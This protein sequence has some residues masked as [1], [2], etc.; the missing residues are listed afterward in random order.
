MPVDPELLPSQLAIQ[1]LHNEL[2][3]PSDFRVN[4]VDIPIKRVDPYYVR[5]RVEQTTMSDMLVG[6]H[7]G[8]APA[9]DYDMEDF[10]PVY[11]DVNATLTGVSV[12]SFGTLITKLRRTDIADRD[13]YEGRSDVT[14]F[15]DDQALVVTWPEVLEWWG[16][17]SLRFWYER[18]PMTEDEEILMVG[19]VVKLETWHRDAGIPPE[20]QGRIAVPGPYKTSGH[21]HTARKDKIRPATETEA[22][23]LINIINDLISK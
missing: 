21:R 19:E 20:L 1:S 15:E 7:E 13:K 11:P 17:I 16:N 23:A 18:E 5:S 9:D 4:Q 3:A 6:E 2:I 22:F 14:M 8:L 10:K 12:A